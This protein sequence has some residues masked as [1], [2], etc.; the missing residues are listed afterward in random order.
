MKFNNTLSI[1]RL[2]PLI[3]KVRQN[4]TEYS[5]EVRAEK[6]ATCWYK[7][8]GCYWKWVLFFLCSIL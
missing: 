6:Q 1:D 4:S 3:H 2:K 7:K 8:S 5:A